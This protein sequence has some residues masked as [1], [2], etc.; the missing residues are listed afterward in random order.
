MT[1]IKRLEVER[2]AARS[3]LRVIDEKCETA[4][5]IKTEQKHI[6]RLRDSSSQEIGRQYVKEENEGKVA[7]RNNDQIA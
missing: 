7:S 2:D 4:L 1:K 6:F 5:I 3:K